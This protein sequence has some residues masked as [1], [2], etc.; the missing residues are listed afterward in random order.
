MPDKEGLLTLGISSRNLGA[1]T[2][3]G[4]ASNAG[5]G[6]LTVEQLKR[7][8][9]GARA[10]GL[11][12]TMHTSGASPVT[13]LERAGLLGPD[14]QLVHALLNTPEEIEILKRRGVSYSIAPQL[15]ARR[16]AQLG[17][18]Q[19]GE[20][21]AAG[22][23][24]SISTDNTTSISVD[25]FASMRMLFALHSHRMGAKVPL[26]LKRVLQLATLDGA[27]DLGLADRTGSITPGKRA[28]LVV[29][30]TTDVNIAPAPR[31]PYE[32]IVGFAMPSNVDTVIV[33]GRV[34]RRGAKFAALD[35][36]KIVAEAR[37]AATG[38]RDRAKWP[39]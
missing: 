18:I 6:V 24:T 35:H 30:R 5:R 32:A 20:L 27:V 16:G 8:W 34:L 12:I 9:D 25:P 4:P 17:E 23:K 3:G 13:E 26:T 22:V 7:D 33:D 2:V 14:V 15:D 1:L 28:D 21:L 10:L 11:P 37:A 19:L 29:V 39:G 36:G 38:L 31:D